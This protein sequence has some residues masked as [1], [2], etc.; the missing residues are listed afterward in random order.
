[1][2][3]S[4]LPSE[5]GVYD[6]ASELAAGQPTIAHLLRASGYRTAL[7]GKMHFIGPD[8]LH[9]FEQRLTTDVYPS[10]FEW[11]PDWTLAPG[12]RLA[13][14]HNMA[15]LRQTRVTEAAMQTDYDDEVGFEAARHLRDTARL[16]N[17]RP[18][19]LTVS[20][21]VPAR[22][23]GGEARALGSLRGCGHRPPHGGRDSARPGRPPQHPPEGHVPGRRGSA[24]TGAGGHRQARIPRRGQRA[25]P[26][27]RRVAGVLDRT[28][29]ATD[30]IVLF[31]ADHGEML[32]ERGL[33]YKMSFFDGSARVP[34]MAAGPGIRPGRIEAPVS[35]L[36][37]APTIAALAGVEPAEAEFSGVSLEAALTRGEEPPGE[38]AAEYLAEGVTAPALMLRRGRFK[39]IRCG[40]DPEQLFDLAKDPLELHNLASEGT[41]PAALTELRDAADRRW[42]ATAIEQ[43]V[44]AS[45][46]R[47]QACAAR[48]CHR[49]VHPMGPPA[50][51]R[52]IARVRARRGIGAPATGAATPARGAA[53]IGRRREW[54][55]RDRERR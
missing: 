52:S 9:G 11:T 36:D 39:Y 31:T 25:R 40:D 51:A 38:A 4:R 55:A 33:W 45:Q 41:P 26:A 43:Q 24:D 32:G 34:L 16:G 7:A 2:L 18:F 27:R 14:Y 13:W 30:T 53:R 5:T 37:L 48:A 44:R 19:F 35:H 49:R 23:L 28:G 17:G 21:T 46:R 10:D 1:M 3:T 20:F 22:P 42:D 6:N 12:E 54:R 15:S 50:A 47:R 8:Q 29:L